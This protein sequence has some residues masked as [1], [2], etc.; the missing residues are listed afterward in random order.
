MVIRISIER[1]DPIAGAAAAE[2]RAQVAFEGWLELL[3]VL[4]KLVARNGEGREASV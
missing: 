3:G 4:S 1:A 2:G